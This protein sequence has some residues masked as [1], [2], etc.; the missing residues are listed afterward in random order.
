MALFLDDLI[1]QLQAYR[2][3]VGHGTHEVLAWDDY[4]QDYHPIKSIVVEAIEVEGV[5]KGK[6]CIEVVAE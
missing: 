2:E 3:E 6:V 1:E 4:W 5:R